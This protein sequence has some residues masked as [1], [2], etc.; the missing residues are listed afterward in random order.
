MVNIRALPRSQ[1]IILGLGALVI[2]TF[3]IIVIAQYASLLGASLT[4]GG[5]TARVLGEIRPG[6]TVTVEYGT[7]GP[8][9]RLG[10]PRGNSE[11][12]PQEKITLF[13]P[14]KGE[15]TLAARVPNTGSATVRIP[16]SLPTGV[17]GFVRVT[18]VSQKNQVVSL[19]RTQ[20]KE[21]ITVAGSS[22]G[23]AALR[24]GSGGTPSPQPTFAPSLPTR[25][26]SVT[27]TPTPVPS[28]PDLIVSSINLAPPVPGVG[29]RTEIEAVV[30]NQGQA[31]ASPSALQI[32]ID[33]QSDRILDYTSL[34]FPVGALAPGSSSRHLWAGFGWTPPA[35][36]HI[37]EACADVAGQVREA[38]E[39]NNCTTQ[40]VTVTPGVGTGTGL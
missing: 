17:Q 37:V 3:L 33:E 15:Y 32:R 21:R 36:T 18:A 6:A 38:N 1:Q 24:R 13:V 30:Q 34:T 5:F 19:V 40:T 8:G 11:R 4:Q 26:P 12:F 14:G 10:L 23:T 25:F 28:A 7:L 20:T 35:G 2:G 39:E 31:A 27:P 16:D 9:G 22:V 29:Q